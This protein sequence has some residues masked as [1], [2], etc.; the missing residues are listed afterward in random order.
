VDT[1]VCERARITFRLLVLRCGGC[2][3]RGTTRSRLLLVSLDVQVPFLCHQ[4]KTS[5]SHASV[6]V[7]DYHHLKFILPGTIDARHTAACFPPTPLTTGLPA[8][9]PRVSVLRLLRW[10]PLRAA[11]VWLLNASSLREGWALNRML[12]F[13][14]PFDCTLGIVKQAV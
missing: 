11:F 5:S 2:R 7:N 9:A 13:I 3:Q 14:R 1:C 10:G 4:K 6:H 12:G 8:S